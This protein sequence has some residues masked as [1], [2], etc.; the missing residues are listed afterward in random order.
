MYNI[1]MNKPMI[2]FFGY[3][4]TGFSMGWYAWGKPQLPPLG[5]VHDKKTIC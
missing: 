5:M 4:A 3:W 1:A 2:W